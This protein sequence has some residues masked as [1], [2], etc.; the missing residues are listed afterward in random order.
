MLK[1]F[2]NIDVFNIN[3]LVLICLVHQ[4]VINNIF[5]PLLAFVVIYLIIIIIINGFHCLIDCCGFGE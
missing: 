3:W 5:S 1:N 4:P 2:D